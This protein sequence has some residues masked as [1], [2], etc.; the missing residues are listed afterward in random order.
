[1]TPSQANEILDLWKSGAKHYPDSV[2][3]E[4]LYATGDLAA[5]LDKAFAI[6][7]L[8]DGSSRVCAVRTELVR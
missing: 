3:N 2:I 4:A 8:P 5:S 6:H 7:A 1:M